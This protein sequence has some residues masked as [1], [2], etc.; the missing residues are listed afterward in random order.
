MLH[1][2]LN[3]ASGVVA[4][5]EC[6]K[7][8]VV[9]GITLQIIVDLRGPPLSQ[10]CIMVIITI[11]STVSSISVTITTI[12]STTISTITTISIITIIIPIIGIRIIRVISII[13]VTSS[14]LTTLTILFHGFFLR[15][16]YLHGLL[17][18]GPLFYFFIHV[19]FFHHVL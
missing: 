3:S 12:I 1:P 16:L 13:R 8:G 2:I 6:K 5:Y 7:L 10:Q 11:I 9:V 19:I 18:H 4:M 14:L 15:L 17:K